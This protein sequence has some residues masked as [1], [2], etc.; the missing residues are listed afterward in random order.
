MSEMRT[1]EVLAHERLGHELGGIAGVYSHVTQG[2]RD[3][4][5]GQLEREWLKS[6]ARRAAMHPGSPVAALDR[7]LH[8]E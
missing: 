1:P 8:S 7:L 6:L 3:E 2:M 4:L 5:T